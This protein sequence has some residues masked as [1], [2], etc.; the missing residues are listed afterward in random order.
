MEE[1]TPSIHYVCTH[2]EAVE[3]ID[4]QDNFWVSNCGCRESRGECAR[5]RKD[6]CL[7][8]ANDWYFGNGGTGADFKEVTR[9][10]VDGILQEAESKQLV[11]RPFRNPPLMEKVVGICFCCDDCCGYFLDPNDK[12]D[13]GVYIEETNLDLCDDCGICVDVCYFKARQ[14][15]N[16][17][18][19]L[20]QDNC[21]GCGL[22]MDACPEGGIEMVRRK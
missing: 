22:C 5:S 21:Y 19:I 13:K 18:L 3:L 4:S 12:C 10:F 16:G 6:L 7:F 20:E 14:K 11:I 17:Q 2:E 9:S 15:D 1:K 8:F